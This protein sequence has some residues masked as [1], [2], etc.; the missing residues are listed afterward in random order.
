MKH[1]ITFILSRAVPDVYVE[2]ARMVGTITDPQWGLDLEA[3]AFRLTEI[4]VKYTLDVKPEP[5]LYWR[6]FREAFPCYEQIAFKYGATAYSVVVCRL[7]P[8]FPSQDA[9]VKWL[10]DVLNLS[11]GERKL[12][13]LVGEV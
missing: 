3:G 10:S 2:T 9:L 1:L 6:R 13:R 12:L 4:E 7:C 11:P 5:Y 8:E